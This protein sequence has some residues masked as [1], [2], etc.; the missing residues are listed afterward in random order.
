MGESSLCISIVIPNFNYDEFVG[1]AIECA[2]AL[3]WPEVEV[4]AVDDGSTQ[5]SRAR[6][7]AITLICRD[8]VDELVQA[9]DDV[10]ALDAMQQ[11]ALVAAQARFRCSDRGAAL[12][13][14]FRL[15]RALPQRGLAPCK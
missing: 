12:V 5:H 6:H 3:E 1:A 4:I 8:N 15:A 13:A 9:I 7:R 14:P 10:G 11:A 2:L